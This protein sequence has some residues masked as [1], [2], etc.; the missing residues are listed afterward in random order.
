M[1]DSMLHLP[2]SYLSIFDDIIDVIDEHTGDGDI[3]E[4]LSW[5]TGTFIIT[6]L[7]TG[8]TESTTV[9]CL[10]YQNEF[11]VFIDSFDDYWG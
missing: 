7:E 11:I 1:P 9:L 8:L 2:V 6:N 10:P 3:D 5:L 4:S